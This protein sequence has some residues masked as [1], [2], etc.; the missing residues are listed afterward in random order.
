MI[1][2]EWPHLFTLKGPDEDFVNAA[3]NRVAN[4]HYS[5]RL[6]WL[7]PEDCMSFNPRVTVPV[8]QALLASTPARQ[9]MQHLRR[10]ELDFGWTMVRKFCD[11]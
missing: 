2:I 4:L 9:G 6:N 1:R 8:I 5:P 10:L 11:R 3:V 7:E